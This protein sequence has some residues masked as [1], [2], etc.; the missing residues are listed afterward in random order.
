LLVADRLPVGRRVSVANEPT[1]NKDSDMT[2][3]PISGWNDPQFDAVR[4][5][6]ATNFAEH[7]E[8]GAAV[9][10]YLHGEPVV[11]LWGGWYTPEREREWDRNTLVNVFSTTKGLAAFCAHRLAE[12]GRLD[13][14]APVAQYWPEFAAAGKE[15][16][17]VR[18]LLSHRAGMAAIRR[19][20][21]MEDMFDWDTMTAAL[22]EQEPWWTP[23][24][25]HGYHALT[26]G[27]LVGEVVRRIDGRSIGSYW[28]EEFAAPLGLDAHIGTGPEF[29]GRISTL[30]DAPVDPEAPDLIDLF[31]GPDTVGAAAF[32]NPPLAGPDEENITASR[33][34]RG[35]EIPAAN[36][37][38]TAR[39]L[40]R[41]YGGA[42][43][44]GA[45]DGI[46][47]ISQ[48]TLDNALVEQSFGPDACLQIETRFGLGW[49][50]T[51]EFM[52]LGPNP[53]AFGHPGAGGSL[54]YADLDAGIGFGYTMN[55]MQ[56]NLSG[57]PRVNGLID[58]LYASL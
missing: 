48:E 58:A 17:P 40:A 26:Y 13:F 16:I 21:V 35:A 27:W 39:A 57:D 46:H 45:I 4:E 18:W 32:S 7:G 15:S 31:G 19:P 5:A 25:Q 56:Q 8:L 30:M 1:F 33:G 6:F 52:P 53:R 38:A 2:D 41:V 47:V 36:G 14:D 43:N 49:M 42:A 29:D 37:H 22:A 34:W 54:G 3:T 24:E 10:V 28:R 12:E 50:L 9:S 51:S 23:G 11:D 55:Q 44:G 20:L